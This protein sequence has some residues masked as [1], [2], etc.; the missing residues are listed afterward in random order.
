MEPSRRIKHE[1]KWWDKWTP[2]NILAVLLITGLLF[3]FIGTIYG[4]QN[5]W[6]SSAEQKDM[7]L[8]YIED[9]HSLTVE[10]AVMVKT[11]IEKEW[12]PSLDGKQN[13]TDI[14][15]LQKFMIEQRVANK[16][17]NAIYNKIVNG[18]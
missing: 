1:R 15:E 17:L 2:G 11:H 8:D 18:E 13:E 7:V 6:F 12:Y 9:G 5:L 3:A 16:Q 14:R 4:Y 10:E